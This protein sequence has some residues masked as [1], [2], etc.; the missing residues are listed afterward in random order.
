MAPE[1]APGPLAQPFILTMADANQLPPPLL[2]MEA[3]VKRFPGVVALGG[4]SLHLRAGEVLAAVFDE[5]DG[6]LKGIQ[7]GTIQ[8]TVVQ[9]PFQFG[10][11]SSKWM[12]ELATKG[13]AAMAAIPKDKMVDTGV[14]VIHKDNVA[15]FKAKLV[16]LKK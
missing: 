12:H 5:E 4:V 1:F 13:E 6:T 3:I 15:E 11:L 16:E 14:D 9:K 2:R 7:N 10:Y 8:V